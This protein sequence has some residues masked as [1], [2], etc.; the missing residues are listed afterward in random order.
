[1]PLTETVEYISTIV[2]DEAEIRNP[3]ELPNCYKDNLEETK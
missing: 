2:A 3:A 1:M